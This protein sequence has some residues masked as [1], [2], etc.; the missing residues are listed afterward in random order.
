MEAG[1]GDCA[2]A[3]P[4]RQ[5]QPAPPKEPHLCAQVHGVFFFCHIFLKFL[6]CISFSVTVYP[7]YSSLHTPHPAITLLFPPPGV[8]FSFPSAPCTHWPSA[9]PTALSACSLST[10]IFFLR[11]H[12]HLFSFPPMFLL[13]SLH[14]PLWLQKRTV[15]F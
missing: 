13:D 1:R 11:T 12:F 9:P 2:T 15:W 3:A 6:N 5:G 7:P 10:H 4:H 8:L 14:W